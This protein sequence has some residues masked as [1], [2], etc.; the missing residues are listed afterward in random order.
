[1]LV[2]NQPLP[3]GLPIACVGLHKSNTIRLIAPPSLTPDVLRHAIV[4]GWPKGVNKE[5][6]DYG[7]RSFRLSGAPWTTTAGSSILIV[8]I[9]RTFAS[10]GW[11]LLTCV[12]S[13]TKT[14]AVDSLY[15]VQAVPAQPRLFAMC[16]PFADK[17]HLKGDIETGD[18]V[19]IRT[20]L[21]DAVIAAW[22][23]GLQRE[24]IERDEYVVKL[25]QYP[26]NSSLCAT[27]KVRSV[28]SQIIHSF[29]TI[30]YRLVNTCAQT[31]GFDEDRWPMV[32]IW[33]F[34]HDAGMLEQLPSYDEAHGGAGSSSM[35]AAPVGVPASL[36]PRQSGRRIASITI[37]SGDML[38]IVAPPDVAPPIIDI[39]N[40]LWRR[41]IKRITPAQPLELPAKSG[42][43]LA[44]LSDVATTLKM[45]GYPWS[46]SGDE[47]IM[48][49]QLLLEIYAHMRRIGWRLLAV[50][51]VCRVNMDTH[52][53][54]FEPCSPAQ[55]LEMFMLSP[56]NP[57]KLNLIHNPSVIHEKTL[58]VVVQAVNATITALPGSNAMT[59]QRGGVVEW[60]LSE[61]DWKPNGAA[62][63]W[64]RVMIVNLLQTVLGLG[65]ELYT[66]CFAD[67]SIDPIDSLVFIR[68]PG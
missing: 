49:Q 33:I 67:A 29:A 52:P 30:G 36:V 4:A 28:L 41:G 1:M 35:P 51:H 50:P 6:I 37:V 8:S 68:V 61:L 45:Y 47:E 11:R 46:C 23:P 53:S 40:A 58:A 19:A 18:S 32:D 54:F 7:L 59:K 34:Q 22:P 48:A 31:C 56:A 16:L 12:C 63:M 25:K 10:R 14:S 27:P 43:Q 60:T 3:P 44:D 21:R 9:I 55:S 62:T 13:S 42:K 66:A 15:F 5:T 38:E 2:A 17:V 24:I 57:N 39:V 65:F 20:A 64:N 26:W